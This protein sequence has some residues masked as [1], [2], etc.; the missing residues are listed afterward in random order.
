MTG[1]LGRASVLRRVFGTIGALL[2]VCL[3]AAGTFTAAA[4]AKTDAKTTVSKGST[5]NVASKPDAKSAAKAEAK[6]EAKST[7]KAEVK[8]DA[9]AVAKAEVK[10]DASKPAVVTA[11]Q[12]ISGADYSRIVITLSREASFRYQLL[13]PDGGDVRRLY[14]DMDNTQVKSGVPSRFNVPGPVMRKVRVSPNKPG[15]VRVVVDTQNLTSYKVFTLDGPFRVVVDVQG[16]AKKQSATAATP[17]PQAKGAQSAA[18]PAKAEP[19][20]KGKAVAKGKAGAKDEAAAKEPSSAKGAGKNSNASQV[21]KKMARQLVEQL[22]LTVKTVMIDAGHGGKDPGARSKNGLTEK[23]VTLRVAKLLGERLKAKG[24]NVLYTRTTDKYIPLETRTALANAQKADLFLAIH[25]NAHGDPNSSGME[26]YSLNLATTPEEVRVAARE[27]AVD[28]RRI[29]DMQSILADLM[30]TSR[31]TE[32]RDFAKA[33]HQTTLNQ[34]RKSLP[35][36]DRGLHEAPFYVLMGANMP[37]VLI[38]IGYITNPAESAKLVDSMYL[39]QLA[40]GLAE[41]VVAYKQR[42]ERYA[43]KE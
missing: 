36:R 34:A 40:K 11:V 8:N 37:A 32:S 28:Q 26:T 24:F 2:L 33:A 20:G 14:V 43:A 29:G 25:C 19:K 31:L 18:A 13:P 23:T 30:L 16:E 27:N 3:V 1:R 12:Q 39:D 41:G 6:G 22:G 35:V 10:N 9:K 15:V 5:K 7:A 42:I 4:A 21:N 38:E 17:E